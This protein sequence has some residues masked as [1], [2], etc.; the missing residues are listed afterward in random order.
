M[1]IRTPAGRYE[2]EELVAYIHGID[3]EGEVAHILVHKRGSNIRFSG[4]LGDH[5]VASSNA[6]DMASWVCEAEAVW[7]LGGTFGVA[8]GW[9]NV[10]ETLE[11]MELLN[12]KA[13]EKKKEINESAI[14]V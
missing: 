12:I 4:K 10:P 6:G 13:A 1:A 8:R 2:R 5:K 14:A 3:L 7:G 11:K 9:M